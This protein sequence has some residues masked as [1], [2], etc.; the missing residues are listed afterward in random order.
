MSEKAFHISRLIEKHLRGD[1]S[2]SDRVELDAWLLT[3]TANQ[4][5]FEK[6]NSEYWVKAELEKF[7]QYNK[8]AVKYLIRHM[9][10]A[11]QGSGS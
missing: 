5:L 7:N 4:E 10:K 2:N 9:K 3:S 6:L 1:L 8:E 11:L